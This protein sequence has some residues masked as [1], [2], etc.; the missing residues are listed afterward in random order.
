MSRIRAAAQALACVLLAAGPALAQADSTAATV[1]WGDWVVA[2]LQPASAVLVPVAAAA[3]TAGLYRV[4]PWAALLLSRQRIEMMVQGG[5]A[6]GL[7]A[8]AGA[9]KGRALSVPLGSA[10]IA[11]GVQHVIDT[12]PRRAI[13]S[14]GGPAGIAGMIFRSLPLDEGASARAVLEPALR[15]LAARGLIT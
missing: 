12:S 4:A 13:R 8:V 2:V 3:L 14:A 10:V 5:A 9:V 15:D 6:Y 11:E 1:P 7:N